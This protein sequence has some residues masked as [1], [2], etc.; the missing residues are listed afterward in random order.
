[1]EFLFNRGSDGDYGCE[2]DGVCGVYLGDLGVEDVKMATI[3]M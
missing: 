3:F 2:N 1:M